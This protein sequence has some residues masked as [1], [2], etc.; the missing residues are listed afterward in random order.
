MHKEETE[1]RVLVK[2]YHTEI[3]L[4]KQYPLTKHP[5][6]LTTT[7]SPLHHQSKHWPI[8]FAAPTASGLVLW[9]LPAHELLSTYSSIVPAAERKTF[10]PLRC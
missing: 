4:R 6:P 8:R 5:L 3:A 9:V 10:K 7:Q 1:H 2:L